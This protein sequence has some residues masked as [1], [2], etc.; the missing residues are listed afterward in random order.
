MCGIAAVVATNGGSPDAGMLKRM[1]DSLFHR[2]P[3]DEGMYLDGAVG[4]GFR[5]LAIIDVSLDSH[6]PMVS[7]DQGLVIVFNGEI[8]NYIELREELIGYGHVFR[9]QGDTEVLLHAYQQWGKDCLS[10]LNGM[11]A[12]LIHDRRKRIVFGARDRFGVKPLYYFKAPQRILF[13]SEIKGILASG[14]YGSDINIHWPTAA[15]FLLS[16]ELDSSPCS[17]YEGIQQ[18]PSGSMFELQMDG[19]MIFQPYWNLLDLETPPTNDPYRTYAELF[20]DAIKLRMRSDV[21]VGVCLSGG[22]DSSSII[23]EM[24]RLSSSKVEAFSYMA[25]E[26]DESRYI[27]DTVAQ[28]GAVLNLVDMS[29]LNL[30][31]ALTDVLKFHD[32][33]VH[34]INVVIGFELMRLAASKGVKVVLNGQGAD[35]TAAGYTSYFNEYWASLI[36]RARL[37][38]ACREMSAYAAAH[39]VPKT[40]LYK[41]AGLRAVATTVA[42]WPVYRLAKDMIAPK[43]AAVSEWFDMGFVRAYPPVRERLA[44]QSLSEVLC[45]AV[46]HSPLPLYLRV[47]DR[48]SMGNSVESRLPFMDYRLVSFLFSMPDEY[49][50]RGEWSKYIQR[51]AL[52][53]KIPESVRMRVDKM[54]FPVPLKKWMV[55]EVLESVADALHSRPC[56]ERGIY[57]WSAL[58][59]VIDEHRR[60]EVD[61]SLW[62]FYVGQFEVWAQT[63]HH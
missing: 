6:Q 56:R 1:T 28:S 54:G 2:G 25:E 60:G 38:A 27:K 22:L 20:E 49:K 36:R 21:P 58:S 26:F 51:R 43:Q 48:N 32:E 17:F 46:E 3:D 34:S 16:G 13:A 11:W 10:R 53:R 45:Y 55:G 29:R 33:P 61:A 63:V 37:I 62:L 14:M 18:I 35:E 59:N 8:Y 50:L 44:P 7:D 42:S 24:A 5:R 15:I 12:F 30:W 47:E 9:T 40:R 23:C 19:E 39:H 52:T 4:L 41:E 31:S 57:N